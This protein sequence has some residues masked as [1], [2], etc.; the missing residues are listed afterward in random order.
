MHG[1]RSHAA[2]AAVD[3][4]RATGLDAEQAKTAFTSLTGHRPQLPPPEIAGELAGRGF[5]GLGQ[6]R[7]QPWTLASG[8]T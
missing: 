4:D 1:D 6:K 8:A 2:R 3:E 7:I 5:A